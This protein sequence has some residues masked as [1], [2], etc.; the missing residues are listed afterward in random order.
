M[1]ERIEFN[2]VP[3]SH[4]IG[5]GK[6]FI[7]EERNSDVNPEK[8]H[9]E[10][11][12][13][14]LEK[15]TRA[16]S[17]L[18]SEFQHLKN[19]SEG[20]VADIVDAQIE[21]LKD[22]ELKKSILRKIKEE[23]YEA[24]YAIFS[25]LNEFI[26]IME[27]SDASWL[28][29]RTIDLMTIRDQLI[30]AAKNRSRD[31][32]IEENSVVFATAISPTKMIELSRSHIAGVVMQKGGLTSHAVILSQ[33]LD[34][35]CIISA[36]WKNKRIKNGEDIIID[37]DEG[38]V[39]V[40]PKEKE[41][42]HYARLKREQQKNY[43]KE[44]EIVEK[45]SKTK[46]G[47]HFL[48]QAN[49]EFL[50]ELPRIKTHGAEGVGLL[51]TETILFQKTGFDLEAQLDFYRKVVEASGDKPV[52][53]RLFDAGG[54]K[55]LEDA[56]TESNPFLGWRGIRML[57]DQN[58]LLTNQLKA[59]YIL[60]GEYPG[61]IKLLVPMVSCNSEIEK[62]KENI[63]SIKEE[64]KSENTNFDDNLP[65]GVMVEVPSVALMADR[66][67]KLVDFFS[68]GTNDLTQYTLAVD[69]GNEKISTLYQP[70]HPAVWKLIRMTKEGADQ[71][72][73]PVTVCGEMAS[74]PKA[75]ACLMGLGITNLS[76]T[77]SALP[78]VKSMLCN[79]S[80]SEMQKL[81]EDVSESNSPDE[82]ISLLEGFGS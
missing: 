40:R 46:C 25:T 1:T 15:C 22:P 82:V 72:G 68:I 45:P 21:T 64:L 4:G 71:Y 66:L 29:D 76:M 58:E 70:F 26:H 42:V 75:A 69:R 61:R 48:L 67:A 31:E 8:I 9:E 30:D 35:P 6:A 53:I 80:L 54:D 57:L 56:E 51:R 3:A 43:K 59:I 63:S 73:I 38:T 10:D 17:K 41:E 20:E 49:V 33:S 44:L 36:K 23:R 28:N 55:L 79:H 62:L 16:F 77:T 12:D 65:L 27:N 19:E 78:K 5:I 32:S 14:N 11:I 74:K 18:K 50:E 7:L 52:T 37:G 24:E 39:V 47:A 81:A 13:Y 60:S 34:I 2:G